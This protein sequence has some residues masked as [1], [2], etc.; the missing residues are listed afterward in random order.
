MVHHSEGPGS[1]L[2]HQATHCAPTHQHDTNFDL[3]FNGMMMSWKGYITI[4]EPI[5]KVLLNGSDEYTYSVLEWIG[6]VRLLSFEIDRM[7]MP[8][9]YWNGSD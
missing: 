7:G 8:T 9:Q 4:P 3:T 6:W 1:V 2:H 5:M